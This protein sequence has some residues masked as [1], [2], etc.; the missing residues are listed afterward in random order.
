MSIAFP[1]K[2]VLA[3]ER[4]AEV[5]AIL[6]RLLLEVARAQQQNEVDDDRS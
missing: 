5:V 1:T 6:S 3:A 4:R 2:Q